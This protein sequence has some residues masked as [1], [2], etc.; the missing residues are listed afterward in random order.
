MERVRGCEP[1]WKIFILRSERS[2][3]EKR[4]LRQL[5]TLRWE[6]L[7]AELL[8]SIVIM[9]LYN[10]VKWRDLFHIHLHK[11]ALYCLGLSTDT[12]TQTHSSTQTQMRSL[13]KAL[14]LLPATPRHTR[15]WLLIPLLTCHSWLPKSK[16]PY[17]ILF[18][19]ATTPCVILNTHTHTP[20]WTTIRMHAN[21]QAHT[22][23]RQTQFPSRSQRQRQT[24]IPLSKRF[25][26]D[27]SERFLPLIFDVQRGC[28]QR[29]LPRIAT[30]LSLSQH[31]AVCLCT[32]P[33]PPA[34]T[35]NTHTRQEQ[36]VSIWLLILDLLVWLAGGMVTF[37]SCVNRVNPDF[38]L[39]PFSVNIFLFCFVFIGET[40][41]FIC[42]PF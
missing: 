37:S 23:M 14:P 6:P 25:S 20:T 29:G 22:R 12:H 17:A 19:N 4:A 31:Y 32:F 24:A 42:Q 16:A 9:Y 26:D 21:T 38:F 5:L 18:V 13:S 28:D 8:L 40:G 39:Y 33:P 2:K 15:H 35:E 27:E 36:T 34:V 30:L 3:E 11:G 41:L 10:T 7:C 1:V